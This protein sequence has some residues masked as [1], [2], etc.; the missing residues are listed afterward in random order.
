ML[1]ISFVFLHHNEEKNILANLY[2]SESMKQNDIIFFKLALQLKLHID[3][4]CDTVYCQTHR[5]FISDGLRSMTKHLRKLINSVEQ[6]LL[7]REQTLNVIIF[8]I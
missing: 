6:E 4:H 1:R 3:T 2:H 7:L 8:T 5:M